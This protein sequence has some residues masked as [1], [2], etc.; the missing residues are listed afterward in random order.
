MNCFYTNLYFIGC[1]DFSLVKGL[2]VKVS[3]YICCCQK[4]SSV[5]YSLLKKIVQQVSLLESANK[6]V[7]IIILILFVTFKGE[8]T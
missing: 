3:D 2:S 1:M 7:K 5:E 4:P 6:P 8:K